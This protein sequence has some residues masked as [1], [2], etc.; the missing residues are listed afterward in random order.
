M[1]R[2]CGRLNHTF[3]SVLV[4]AGLDIRCGVPTER[5]LDSLASSCSNSAICALKAMIIC[6]CCSMTSCNL[7]RSCG[8]LV[9]LSSLDDD[10]EESDVEV[11]C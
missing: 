6:C 1:D 2:Q 10:A 9:V 5:G 8:E 4:D 3:G 11:V 7:C